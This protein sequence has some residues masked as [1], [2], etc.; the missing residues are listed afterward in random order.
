MSDFEIRIDKAAFVD[1]LRKSTDDAKAAARQILGQAA[2]VALAHAKATHKFKDRTG[3]LRGSIIRG[4]RSTWVH[5]I[6]ATAKHAKFVEG[7]TK[8]HEIVARRRQ[9]LRFVMHGEVVFRKRVH[10]PGTKATHFMDDA[11]TE[12]ARYLDWNLEPAIAKAFAR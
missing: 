9:S 10:H 5:F 7:G 1:W 2:A 6:K 3:E 8:P 12:G 4:Q 11:A